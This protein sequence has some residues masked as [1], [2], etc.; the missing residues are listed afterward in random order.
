MYAIQGDLDNSSPALAGADWNN[1]DVAVISM[2]LHHMP[3]PV[4]ILSQLRKRL[5]TGGALIVV[6]WYEGGADADETS[7]SD[8]L[9]QDAMITVN[10]GEK[11]WAGFTPKGLSMLLE[12]AGLSD[13]DVK[14]PGISFRIPDHIGGPLHGH[15]KNLMFVKAVNKSSPQQDGRL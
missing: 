8:N 7:G 4:K 12:R 3:E 11:I 6:E 13:V 2:A 14:V 9:D 1:F 15:E 10:G 5:N